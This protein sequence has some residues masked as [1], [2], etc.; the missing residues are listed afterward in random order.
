MSA[1]REDTSKDETKNGRGDINEGR[2]Q[3]KAGTDS[4][5]TI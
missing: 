1:V 3:G 5:P 2:G 4:C